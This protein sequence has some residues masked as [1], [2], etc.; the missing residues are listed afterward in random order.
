MKN[1]QKG[2]DVWDFIIIVA[3]LSWIFPAIPSF[4][5]RMLSEDKPQ[6]EQEEKKAPVNPC[7]I[8]DCN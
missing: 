6:V 8:G 4:V 5:D 7:V 3:I 1:K 2:F